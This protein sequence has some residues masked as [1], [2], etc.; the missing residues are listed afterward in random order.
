[1]SRQLSIDAL[2]NVGNSKNTI[3]SICGSHLLEPKT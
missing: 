2:P 1:M 3:K